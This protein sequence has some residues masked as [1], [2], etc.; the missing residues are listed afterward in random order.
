MATKL[1]LVKVGESFRFHSDSPTWTRHTLTAAYRYDQ[2]YQDV[3]WLELSLGWC[4]R[5][6]ELV[7]RT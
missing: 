4:D 1:G 6:V 5:E 2:V 7:P 3:I